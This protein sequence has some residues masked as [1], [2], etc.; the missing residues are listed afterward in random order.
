M[1]MTNSADLPA[2]PAELVAKR[3]AELAEVKK[4]WDAIRDTPE[5]LAK[6]PDGFP[7]QKPYRLKYERAQ[8]DLLALTDPVARGHAVHGVRDAKVGSIGDTEV[9]IRG[10]AEKLGPA[11]PRGFLSAFEVPGTPTIN[12]RQSGRLELAQWLT[13][14]KNPL[15]ARVIVNRVWQHLFAQGLVTTVDN[16]GVTGDVP[17][18]PD[19]LDHLATRFIRDGWSIKKLVRT[20]VLTRAYQLATETTPAHLAVDPAN[21]LVW[22][23]TPRRLDAEELRD[24][25]LA[26]AGTLDTKRPAGS[27]A[28]QLKM[29]EMR[30]DGPEARGIHEHADR[31]GYRS[32]YLPLLRGVTPHTLEAFDPVEQ[33]LVTGQRSVTT[34]PGQ[35]LFLLNSSFVRRQSLALAERLLRDKDGTDAER[36]RMAYRLALGR[37]PT[38]KENER[39]RTFLAEYESGYRKHNAAPVENAVRSKDARTAAWLAFAQALFGC[40]EFRYLK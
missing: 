13:S 16:F 10:E 6:G 4:A 36:I 22:R 1:L 33:A 29:V 34:V 24:T 17:S 31:S 39:A 12:P 23:H 15:A 26:S 8:E 21:R 9:R 18:H 11:V 38:D 35:A 30:D 7:K 40:A 37:A 32:V 28:R 14:P 5:G 2:V 27:P 19:L 25:M 20:L 3:K